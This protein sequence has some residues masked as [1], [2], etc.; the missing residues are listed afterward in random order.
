MKN[1]S[2]KVETT[3]QTAIRKAIDIIEIKKFFGFTKNEKDTLIFAAAHL[4]RFLPAPA[5]IEDKYTYC[6]CCKALLNYE[7]NQAFL[8]IYCTECG[9]NIYNIKEEA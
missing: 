9:Q 4:K 2:I 5:I 3:E 7:S 1:Q 8:N 6:P